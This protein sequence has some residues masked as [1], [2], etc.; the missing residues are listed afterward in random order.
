MKITILAL[1][2]SAF[3]YRFVYLYQ[4]N[5]NFDINIK[6]L[7]RAEYPENPSTL[8]NHYGRYSKRYLKIKHLEE[9]NYSFHLESKNPS[10]AKISFKNIDLSLWVPKLPDYAKSSEAHTIVSLVER[11]WNRQQV[12]FYPGSPHLEITGGDSI[13]NTQ[14]S[15]VALARNCLN[16]GLWEVL[17]YMKEDGQDKLYYQGWFDLPKGIYKKI[18]ENNNKISYWKHFY[19]LEHW[20]DPAGKKINLKKIRKVLYTH[21]SQF[22]Y[23]QNERIIIAGEQKNKIRTNKTINI[24]TW[25]DFF[26]SENKISY[27]AFVPPGYYSHKHTKETQYGLLTK[28]IKGT[29]RLVKAENYQATHEIELEYQSKNNQTYKILISGIDF[30][31]LKKLSFKNYNKGLYM[32][33]GIGVPPFYQTYDKL[34]DNPPNQ[35]YYM[36]VL[37]D[38]QGKWIDHH[39]VGIDGPVIH[40]DINDS[41]VFHLYLLSYERHSLVAHYVFSPYKELSANLE[42]FTSTL[43]F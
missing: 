28:F 9:N 43:K 4:D 37:L 26:I 11:E 1:I 2:C 3:F 14:I 42:K 10:N 20:F 13:E 6:E 24:H 19:R 15:K 16:A 35:N 36:S 23:N 31:S 41:K 21:K 38:Q 39:S 8:G 7:S 25:N 40:K 29:L 32:P 5:S 27:A 33:M 34:K 30:K 17:L 12:F 22:F 18:F